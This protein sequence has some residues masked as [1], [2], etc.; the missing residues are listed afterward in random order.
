MV[1]KG[2]AFGHEGRQRK[3]IV[4]WCGVLLLL[5]SSSSFASDSGS[6]SG[7][8]ADPSGAVVREAVVIL[9]NLETEAER[10]CVTNE[11]GLYSFPAL[12]AGRYRIE[13]SRSRI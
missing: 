8:V 5:L 11:D 7:T 13:I 4:G 12:P 3:I 2:G 6:I 10:N 1:E 9:R